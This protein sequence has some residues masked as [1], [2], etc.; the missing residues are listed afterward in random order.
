M[1]QEEKRALITR[2]LD[3]VLTPEELNHLLS[4]NTPLKHYIGFELSGQIHIGQGLVTAMKIKDFLDAGVDCTIY[5]AD[6]FSWINDKLTGDLDI[7]QSVGV[8]YFKNGFTACLQA[9]GADPT[10][11]HFVT[12]TE[13]YK[14]RL[15]YWQSVIEISKNT[16]LARMMRSV[17]IMGRTEGEG[18]DF[19]KLIYP[20]MQAADIFLLQA[21]LAHA[22]MDQRKAHVIARDTGLQ[23]KT[24]KLTDA[25]GEQIKPVALHHH[26][27]LGL[28]PPP[29]WPMAKEE[30]QQALSEMKMSKSKP[31]S[32]IF[33]T[34]EPEE[35]RQ[36]LTK[37]F[38]PEKETVYNPVLDWTKHLIFPLRNGIQ[39]N[40][41]E[42]FGGNVS[43]S[44]YQD[45]EKDFQEG[46]L[47]PMDLKTAVAESLIETLAP[48]RDYF[49]ND[50]AKS[51]L[52]N[53]KKILQS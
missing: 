20:P 7:I 49:S 48:I 34:D 9:L 50:P 2:N 25:K 52:D 45:L 24:N 46:A 14:N 41:D 19:A 42:K 17:S 40:R 21:N 8:A 1:T 31:G 38:C 12:S 29:K 3:E 16:T 33:I 22:G 39:I 47:H 26:L 51:T 4:T 15:D 23:I 53:L 10:K 6:W 43:Y 36:K 11:V 27:L 35:I 18:M 30:L 13:L 44:S 5:L 28:T 37:A 32:A